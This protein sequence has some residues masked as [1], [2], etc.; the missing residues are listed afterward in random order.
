M[1]ARFRKTKGTEGGSGN[2]YMQIQEITYDKDGNKK[3]T[4]RVQKGNIGDFNDDFFKDF[5]G[6]QGGNG[7][8]K[9]IRRTYGGSGDNPK[10]EIKIERRTAKRNQQKNPYLEDDEEDN[11]G[12][13]PKEVKPKEEKPTYKIE[14]RTAKRNQE[15][16]P[17]LEDE[18]EEKPTPKKNTSNQGGFSLKFQVEKPQ[19]KK[20]KNPYLDDE[21]E[22]SYKPTTNKKK[23][24]TSNT[25]GTF[26]SLI[27]KKNRNLAGDSQAGPEFV[28][29]CIEEHN[30]LR[31]QHGVPPLE[32]DPEITKIAQKYAEYMAAN[33]DFNHSGNN[34]NGD[35]LGENIYFAT[36]MK[37]EQMVD[38]WYNEI[39]DY[40]FNNPGGNFSQTGHFTQ[41]VWKGSKYAGFGVAK[42][43]DGYYGV[44]NYYPAGNFIGR[45]PQNVFPK[46]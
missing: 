24:T 7:T 28:S 29:R 21:E 32:E 35:S 43:R 22:P 42:G 46:Q 10:Q 9:I 38:A 12:Y 11:T 27:N 20:E 1:F 40:D 26:S 45:Y 19:T 3:V 17:Y 41:V 13:K 4:T 23:T 31:A 15:K 37:P 8:T 18:E 5:E 6:N 44:G 30:R 33:D 2:G 36:Y 39:D 16:N 14:R 34:Y 25:K